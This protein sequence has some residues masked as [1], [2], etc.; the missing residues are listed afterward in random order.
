[1]YYMPVL[2]NGI[3]IKCF[4]LLKMLSILFHMFQIKQI[5]LLSVFCY[6][7][8]RLQGGPLCGRNEGFRGGKALFVGIILEDG[9]LVER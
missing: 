4:S 5:F 2:A 3:L 1:M 9:L 6:L 8:M 7:S